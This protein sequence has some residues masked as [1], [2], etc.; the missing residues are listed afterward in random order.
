MQSCVKK[1]YVPA[2]VESWRRKWWSS[3]FL[4]DIEWIIRWR[5]ASGRLKRNKKSL[6]TEENLDKKI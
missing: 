1:R 2:C 5:E 3:I 4:A 6:V